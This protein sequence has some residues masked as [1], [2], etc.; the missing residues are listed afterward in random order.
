MTR[1]PIIRLLALLLALSVGPA[2]SADAAPTGGDVNEL[3][4]AK[5]TA[6]LAGPWRSSENRA[7]DLYR[8]PRETLQFFALKPDQTL[9]EVTPGS[10]W[11]SE[12][13]APLMRDRGRYI[14]AVNAPATGD[15][16]RKSAEALQ[17][18]FADDP[19]R[20]GKARIV[21]FDQQDLVLGEPASAD[22]VLTFRN[23]HNWVMGDNAPAMFKAFYTV[24]KPGGTL[25]VVDHRARDDASLQAVERSGYLPTDHVLKLAAD[26]GFVLTGSSEINANPHDTKDYPTGVWTLPPVLRKG[27][28]DREQYLAIGES[29]R[30]TLKFTKPAR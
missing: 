4:G 2:W 21:E 7:R 29:D 1:R 10:G 16:F 17:Q 19:A 24:L 11:Y 12:I 27:D 18:K 30:M 9:I 23:V 13:L 26:A 3:T 25:G 20:Y 5:Y 28:E 8:H 14:A 15:R 22:V 6:V